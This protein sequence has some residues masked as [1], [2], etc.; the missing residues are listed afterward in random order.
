MRATWTKKFVCL[1]VKKA[2][3]IVLSLLCCCL[4]STRIRLLA[5]CIHLASPH[6]SVHHCNPTMQP[7]YSPP[8][9]WRSLPSERALRRLHRHTIADTIYA[10]R[11]KLKLIKI[12]CFFLAYLAVGFNFH[13]FFCSWSWAIFVR[14]RLSSMKLISVQESAA[15]MMTT[16]WSY[17]WYTIFICAF[18]VWNSI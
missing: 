12:Q 17:N 15:V 1:R 7:F 8:R 5:L 16:G 2:Q 3:Q 4:P 13:L 11:I 14:Q 9:G 10:N 18:A 6:C